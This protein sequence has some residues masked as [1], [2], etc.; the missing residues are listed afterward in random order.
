MNPTFLTG[1]ND[2]RIEL[3]AVLNFASDPWQLYANGYLEAANAL[4]EDL[5]NT[6][7]LRSKVD[8]LVSPIVFLYRHHIEL[9]IKQ[10]YLKVCHYL[11]VTPALKTTHTL[12]GNWAD[13][14]VKLSQ[15]AQSFNLTQE[16][17]QYLQVVEIKLNQFATLDNTSM[18]FRYPVDK[19]GT[20]LL[21]DRTYLHLGE[22]RDFA[23]DLAQDLENLHL[24]LS[25]WMQIESDWFRAYDFDFPNTFDD[26]DVSRF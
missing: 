12:L 23:I 4:V 15:A 21:P 13:F 3:K 22:L 8:R 16:T 5:E 11:D 10:L 24:E 20:N 18:P 14:Q 7:I 1:E 17:S 25:L 6:I 26:Y 19:S 9:K 2:S